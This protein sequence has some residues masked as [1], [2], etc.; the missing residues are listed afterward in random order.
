M[1]LEKIGSY[2]GLASPVITP[3]KQTLKCIFIKSLRRVFFQR[4]GNLTLF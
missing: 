1:Q 2:D 3:V 4:R